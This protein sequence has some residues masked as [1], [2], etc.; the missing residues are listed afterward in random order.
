MLADN[1]TAE[2]LTFQNNA[3]VNAGQAVAIEADGDK[4]AFKNC[5]FVGN[6]DVLFTNNDG[7][8]QYY[9]NCYIEGTTDF[10]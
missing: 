4:A 9:K 3:G 6:Q 2:N 7:S 10:I 5:R 1:F 8:R